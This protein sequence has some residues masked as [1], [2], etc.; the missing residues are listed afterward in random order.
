MSRAGE[1]IFGVFHT[2]ILQCTTLEM[3]AVNTSYGCSKHFTLQCENQVVFADLHCMKYYPMV[4]V[5]QRSGVRITRD[6]PYTDARRSQRFPSYGLKTGIS[7]VLSS[8]NKHVINMLS[9]LL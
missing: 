6:R 2:S 4:V 3:Y 1:S 5:N 9:Y 8:S 7:H